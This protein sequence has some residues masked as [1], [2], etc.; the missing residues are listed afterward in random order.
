MK[1]IFCI[2]SKVS[3]TLLILSNIALA[4]D[5]DLIIEEEM[6]SFLNESTNISQDALLANAEIDFIEQQLSIVPK[7]IKLEKASF[8]E[9]PKIEASVVKGNIVSVIYQ[10]SNL[11]LKTVGKALDKGKLK[12]TV[13]I[14]NLES[15]KII[16]GTI[17]GNNL[18]EVRDEGNF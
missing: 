4:D 13:R 15:N 1:N 17:I 11:K 18:V 14:Q 3:V 7:K 12:E 8:K 2:L 16:Y 6:N 10:S 9:E 5:L